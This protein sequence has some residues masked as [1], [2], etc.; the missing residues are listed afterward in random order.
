MEAKYIVAI[1]C[2]LVFVAF[3]STLFFKFRHKFLVTCSIVA[4]LL[5]L[6][7][8]CICLSVCEKYELTNEMWCRLLIIFTILEDMSTIVF[9]FLTKRL[10][11]KVE[12]ALWA[13]SLT[14]VVIA[15]VF[16]VVGCDRIYESANGGSPRP[17]F[18]ALF[19]LK[20][21]GKYSGSGSL[22]HLVH[23]MCVRISF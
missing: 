20:G 19:T 1:I 2:I 7:S 6:C 17:T 3:V 18:D 11:I 22:P 21:A 23:Q 13:L 15:I 12:I 9:I 10:K 14:S 16:I 5:S 4:I 8:A